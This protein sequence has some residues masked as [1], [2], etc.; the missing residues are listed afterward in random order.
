MKIDRRTALALSGYALS[1][2]ALAGGLAS[3]RLARAADMKTLRLIT[4]VGK[5]SVTWTT[6]DVLR[7]AL[8]EALKEEVALQ[9]VTG[10]DGLD[11][12]HE[13]LQVGGAEVRVYGAAIM[14]TQYA[15][16]ALKLEFRLEDMLPI[17]KVTNGFSMT[18]FAKQGGA[19]K[20]W[21]D[22]AATKP[23]TLSSLQRHTAAYLAVLM[24]ERKGGLAPD[25]TFRTTIG[26]VIDDV[27]AGRSALGVANTTQVSMMTGQLLPIASFGSQR[28]PMLH[29]TPTFAEVTGNPMLA[30]TES[31][32]M[33]A[34]PKLAS[35]VAARITHA[36]M[37]VGNEPDVLDRAEAAN[38]PL[39]I[40][41][42]DV[43]AATMQRNEHLL[44]QILG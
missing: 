33:L 43:L 34:S 5:Q 31:V 2:Y 10:N 6:C 38:V 7:P 14:A 39:A 32:G 13:V 15:G 22:L 40:N 17:A 27:V 1:G 3:V 8:Q 25:V 36:F 42:P 35:E 18:L 4:S 37:T 24:M 23:L 12:M 44:D 28:N 11:A 16:R 9:A 21:A 30:F 20:K 41:R 29:G 19:V 26:E